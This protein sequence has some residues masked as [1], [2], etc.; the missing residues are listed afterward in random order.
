[1][2]S[3]TDIDY[4]NTQFE[5]TVLDRIHGEPTYDSLKLLKKQLKTNAQTVGDSAHYGYLGLVLFPT[6]YATVTNTPF[7]R[8]ANPGAFQL[9]A[10]TSTSDAFTIKSQYDDAKKV[11]KECIGV[12]KAL[13]SN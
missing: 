13:K 2:T 5:V 1:M 6:D 7:V 9:P 10:F 3:T 12:K 11:W 4:A 8:P